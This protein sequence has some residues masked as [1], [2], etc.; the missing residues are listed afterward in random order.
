MQGSPDGYATTPELAAQ[1]A[2][3]YEDPVPQD[4]K[5]VAEGQRRRVRFA[6]KR[7]K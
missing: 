2:I 4:V 7:N 6:V 5:K 1:G 3:N